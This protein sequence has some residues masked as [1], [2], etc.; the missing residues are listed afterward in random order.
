MSGHD[1]E[2]AHRERVLEVLDSIDTRLFEVGQG[3]GQL[4]A[5]VYAAE[6]EA[7]RGSVEHEAA[8]RSQARAAAVQDLDDFTNPRPR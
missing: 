7:V 8:A 6:F 3:R 1:P 5:R 4:W 2:E